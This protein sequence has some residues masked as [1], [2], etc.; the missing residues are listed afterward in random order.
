MSDCKGT[1]KI[2]RE[3]QNRALELYE[4][5]LKRAAI[6]ERLGVPAV[7]VSG[8]IQRARQRREKQQEAVN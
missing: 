4:S 7:N 5:G 3:K 8:M 1:L 6:A 2:V